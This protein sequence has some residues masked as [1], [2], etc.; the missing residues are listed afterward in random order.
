[1][2][3]FGKIACILLLGGT[4]CA[5]P[6]TELPH[7]A[8]RTAPAALPAEPTP[9]SDDAW[10]GS[11]SAWPV[12]V[13]PGGLWV[14]RVPR[15][16][17][18]A[19]AQLM[20]PRG[21][22]YDLRPEFVL[23][24]ADRHLEYNSPPGVRY[25]SRV[26]ERWYALEVSAVPERLRAGLSRLAESL[27]ELA[28]P[29]ADVR[30]YA[31]RSLQAIAEENK[32]FGF[33]ASVVLRRGRYGEAHPWGRDTSAMVEALAKTT[34]RDIQTGFRQLFPARQSVLVFVGPKSSL[35]SNEEL[36]GLFSG[37]FPERRLPRVPPPPG[38][39]KKSGRQ[40]HAFWYDTEQTLLRVLH[41]GPS[42]SDPRAYAAFL[43]L[44]EMMG[45]FLSGANQTFRHS[46]GASYGLHA[47]THDRGI[48]TELMF[49]GWV[50][51]HQVITAVKDHSK[52]LADVRNGDID[53]AAF[54]RGLASVRARYLRLA[55]EPDELAGLLAERAAALRFRCSEDPVACPER[56]EVN[57]RA[58]EALRTLSAK[59]VAQVVRD[60]ID[61]DRIDAAVV[62]PPWLYRGLVRKG[63]L[64]SY[65]INNEG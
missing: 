12:F 52:W 6:R 41:V 30:R 53:Q 45:S 9:S 8:S 59:D 40:F 48:C 4:A 35:P 63:R 7:L 21:Q 18:L 50:P 46:S 38:P 5:T 19:V 24:L 10:L 20:A 61:L 15:R 51:H 11:P 32:D 26:N 3:S 54:A 47:W 43:V 25:T 33:M 29:P 22:A 27:R 42:P 31:V 13:L 44:T 49:G 14:V 56:V 37:L 16:S 17:G 2:D 23:S 57:A 60:H 1:M 36:T 34:H 65:Q 62:G 64:I 58:P 39:R 28:I 55:A